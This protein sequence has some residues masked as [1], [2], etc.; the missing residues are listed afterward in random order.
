MR[1]KTNMCFRFAELSQVTFCNYVADAT[2]S[3]FE[4]FTI[5]LALVGGLQV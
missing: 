3:G 2:P 5:G 4:I 1:L